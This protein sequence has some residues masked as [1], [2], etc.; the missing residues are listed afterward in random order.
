MKQIQI[1]E[2]VRVNIREKYKD[3]FKAWVGKD[4]SAQHRFVNLD[5]RVVMAFDGDPVLQSFDEGKSWGVYEGPLSWPKMSN[6]GIFKFDNVW[7]SLDASHLLYSLNAGKTWLDPVPI[8]TPDSE[9]FRGLGQPNCFS[10]IKTRRGLLVMV[11][12][13]F[14]GQEGPDGQLISATVSADAGRTWKVSRLFGPAPPLP[15]GPEGFGEPAVVELPSQWLWMVMRSLY[16]EL[17]QSI[18]RDGGLS[19]NDP[20]PTGLVS[21]IANCYAARD[22]FTAATVLCFN[23]TIPGLGQ[24]FQSAESVYRPRNNLVFMVSH[25]NCRTWTCPVTVD[26]GGAFYPTLHFSEKTMFVMYQSNK[27]ETEP[28]A[29][30]GLTLVTYDRKEVNAIPEWTAETIQPYIEAG[31]VRHWLAL[32]C[33]RP[34]KEAIESWIS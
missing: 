3:L 2:K 13:N 22:P 10:A 20:T 24:N 23:H 4:C 16:G 17:W 27:D 12:D 1:K 33:H 32:G 26:A 18:S 5:D 25:D 19:W 21:P 9:Y 11:A 14:L 29:K 28:W 30:H 15:N 7:V 34:T 31:L 6:R 8:P